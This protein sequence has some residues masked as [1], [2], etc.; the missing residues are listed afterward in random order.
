MKRILSF[1]IL[2]LMA[3]LAIGFA[4]LNAELVELNYYFGR[5]TAPLSLALV[6]AVVVG[7][8]LG[9]FASMAMLVRA[10]RDNARLRKK[11]ELA[12]KEVLNLRAI[13]LREKP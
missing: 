5:S 10:R 2:L 8:A 11:A 12:R 1:L 9:V 7:A 3:I 6:L 4:V 13:P